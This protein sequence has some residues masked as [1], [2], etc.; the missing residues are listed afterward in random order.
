[1]RTTKALLVIITLIFSMQA[2]SGSPCEGLPEVVLNRPTLVC[3]WHQWN[4]K[5]INI[6][7][8][9]TIPFL[10]SKYGYAHFAREKV[11]IQGGY[12]W[13]IIRMWD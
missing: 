4:D 2:Y 9:M 1:M 13:L 7:L 6:D 11:I 5:C 12:S 8:D 3:N 10:V